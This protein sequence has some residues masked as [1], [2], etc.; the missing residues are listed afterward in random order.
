MPQGPPLAPLTVTPEQRTQLQSLLARPTTPQALARRARIVL[1][2][3]T[4]IANRAIA[5]EVGVTP[6]TV[7]L[8]RRRFIEQGVEGLFDR[9]RPGRPRTIT[10][11][12]VEQIVTLTIETTPRDAT[13]WSLRSMAREVGVS[14]SVVFKVWRMFG[15]KPHLSETFK[16]STDL[17]FVEKVR[18]I[19]GLYMN[20][21]DHALVLCVDEKTSIQALDRTQPMLPMRRGQVERRTHDYVRH[22]VTDLFAALNVKSGE[23]IGS[24]KRR[25]RAVEVRDFLAEID[26]QVPPELDIH[27]VMDNA[28]S[29]KAEPVRT[30]LEQHPRYHVHFTPTS[31]SWLNLVERWFGLLTE[32][33][34]K[35]GIHRSTKEL[36]Q[37]IDH[38]LDVTNEDPRP[39]T[40]TKSADDIFAA[41]ARF[42]NRNA[43]TR[44]GH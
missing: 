9:P 34:I 40:W 29:H 15:L 6:L 37:A 39:F 16:L 23:V 26:T 11:E 14:P 5:R 2:S 33:Q 8:W 27:V 44:S 35:R 20:P 36:E 24:T 38:F 31:S 21:P 1:L 42:C 32:K 28:S 3:D 41:L 18:D 10:D 43:I 30:W 12:T 25:H 7:G 13:H 17:L 4:G 22:G 19:V